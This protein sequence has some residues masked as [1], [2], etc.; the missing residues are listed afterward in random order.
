MNHEEMKILEKFHRYPQGGHFIAPPPPGF[1][2][3]R[4]KPRLVNRVKI[5]D[6]V[7]RKIQA[8]NITKT[9]KL[10]YPGAFVVSDM[11]GMMKPKTEKK[12][13]WWKRMF[14]RASETDAKRPWVHKKVD[15]EENSEEEMEES[16][17]SQ[18]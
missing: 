11:V 4:E 2:I 15:R 8:R 9:N 16:F 12:E 10:I 14:G 18:V 7:I 6:N 17:R 13:P 1:R 5:V 3:A